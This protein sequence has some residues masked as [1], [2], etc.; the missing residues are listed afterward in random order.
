MAKKGRHKKE[1]L[2]AEDLAD[3]KK[4]LHTI[5]KNA[6]I[7]GRENLTPSERK[8]IDEFL[9]KEDDDIYA[10]TVKALKFKKHILKKCLTQ[11]ECTFFVDVDDN[12]TKPSRSKKLTKMS[13]CKIEQKACQKLRA[14]LGSK[15]SI[16]SLGD[17]LDLGK[18]HQACEPVDL[19]QRG[20]EQ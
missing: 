8:F 10:K 6:D 19:S 11:D 20:R 17:V 16:F 4:F 12:G 13:I 14:A 15:Y 5:S 7:I 1:I 2:E 9:V 18:H 3:W